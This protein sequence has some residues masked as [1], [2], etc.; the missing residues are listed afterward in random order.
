MIVLFKGPFL[1]ILILYHTNKRAQ[2]AFIILDSNCFQSLPSLYICYKHKLCHLARA[3][4]LF[5]I[6]QSTISAS[7]GDLPLALL[8]GERM[9]LNLVETQVALRNAFLVTTL[10][11][12][13]QQYTLLT[14][15]VKTLA[16]HAT[17][18]ILFM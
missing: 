13:L 8:L 12:P 17:T 5:I 10:Q 3:V 16:S 1:K 9:N 6:N 7:T 15:H 4:F 11:T 14:Y 18:V 2:Y